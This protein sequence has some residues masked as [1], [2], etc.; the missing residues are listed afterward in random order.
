M[1]EGS[2]KKVSFNLLGVNFAVK[3]EQIKDLRV[4]EW[5]SQNLVLS[6]MLPDA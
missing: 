1:C 6:R 3:V 5:P 2:F 4:P